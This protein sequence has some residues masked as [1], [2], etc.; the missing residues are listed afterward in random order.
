VS[1]LVV[2]D[3]CLGLYNHWLMPTISPFAYN[4]IF[5]NGTAVIIRFKSLNHPAAISGPT[6]ALPGS[7]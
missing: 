3:S 5:F 7:G 4:N 1:Q 6:P 2:T